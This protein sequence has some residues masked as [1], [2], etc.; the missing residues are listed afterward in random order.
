MGDSAGR[1][2]PQDTMR[3]GIIAFGVLLTA[4]YVYRYWL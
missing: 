2:I 4:I 3:W 1:F